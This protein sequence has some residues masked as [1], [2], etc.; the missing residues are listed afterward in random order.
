ML[1]P[2]NKDVALQGIINNELCSGCGACAGICPQGAI[3][4]DYPSSYKPVIEES[5]CTLCNL[6][7]QICPG[8][9][10]PAVEWATRV[11]VDDGTGMH[12]KF[13]PLKKIFLGRSTNS[14]IHL[15]GA[16]GGVATSLLLYLL[17]T[18]KVEAVAIVA[19]EKGYPVL[20]ITDDPKVILSSSG[21]K[22]S[23]V[24][25]MEHIIKVLKD[26]P[27]RIAITAIPCHLAALHYAME[28][29]KRLAE[30]EVFTIGLF[31][32]D[33]RDYESVHRIADS[34]CLKYPQE[35]KF[36]GWRCGPWPGNA[37]FEIDDGT[38]KD[39][40]LHPSLDLSIPYYALLRCLMCPSRE[41]WLADL[42]LADNHIGGTSDTVILARSPKGY[43]LLR[44]AAAE[45]FIKLTEV[46]EEKADKIV[47][48]TKFVPALSYIHW[49]KQKG[50]PVPFYDYDEDSIFSE[51]SRMARY[52]FLMKYRMF[53]WLRK[54]RII[55]FL[56][57]CPFLM[58]KI[59][60]FLNNFPRSIPGSRTAERLLSGFFIFIWQYRTRD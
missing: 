25:V 37:R 9:G 7:Y 31:C 18:N 39:K 46:D 56:I 16:S 28:K 42:A 2:K 34:L 32:G 19:L 45:G 55:D 1:L 44:H 59:G 58:E 52:L 54:E 57:T 11:C 8:K 30:S 51:R 27:C 17:E 23:P 21:S 47:T 4:I 13:G 50:H 14:K 15:N 38:F 49:R 12:P 40:Q 29:D 33:L 22:Y 20:R 48:R 53:I 60:K 6:C 26:N 41:N 24:P 36:L 35:A 10:W 3:T 5:K 43:E